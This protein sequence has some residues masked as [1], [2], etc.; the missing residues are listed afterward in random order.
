MWPGRKSSQRP[1]TIL[2]VDADEAAAANLAHELGSRGSH[3]FYTATAHV[4]RRLSQEHYFDLVLVDD[5]IDR[6][7]IPPLSQMIAREGHRCVVLTVGAEQR[8]FAAS[9]LTVRGA[10]RRPLSA[11]R[12]HSLAVDVVRDSNLE[13]WRHHLDLV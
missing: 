10:V 7:T 4:G 12:I 2:L 3:V 11:D 1:S 8:T 13:C 6:Q 5:R 9:E